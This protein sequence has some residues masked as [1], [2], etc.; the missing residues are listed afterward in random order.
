VLFCDALSKQH[1]QS[2]S[3]DES[4]GGSSTTRSAALP[5][6][7]GG[8]VG[9]VGL[10][11]LFAGGL[12]VMRTRRT[13]L[14]RIAPS[15][16]QPVDV[17]L[18]QQMQGSDSGDAAATGRGRGVANE[19]PATRAMP[20]IITSSEEKGLSCLQA[21]DEASTRS[22]QPLSAASTNGGAASSQG[23]A[24]QLAVKLHSTPSTLPTGQ[25]SPR[26]RSA[27]SKRAAASLPGVTV[28]TET[29]G[30]TPSEMDQRETS[31][32]SSTLSWSSTPTRK[33]QVAP[34]GAECYRDIK[35]QGPKASRILGPAASSVRSSSSLR[36]GSI[37]TGGLTCLGSGSSSRPLSPAST[38]AS[39]PIKAKGGT[40]NNGG[41]GAIFGLPSTAVHPVGIEHR[42]HSSSVASVAGMKASP[43]ADVK[44][45]VEAGAIDGPDVVQS[46]SDSPGPDTLRA[47]SAGAQTESSSVILPWRSPRKGDISAQRPPKQNLQNYSD[48]NGDAASGFALQTGDAV[49]QGH[50]FMA[51]TDTKAT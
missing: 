29:L 7:I 36:G 2:F 37:D 5:A 20:D 35:V 32:P 43:G 23:A 24:D 26:S 50:P 12:Y 46:L 15:S 8:V 39:S 33:N 19:A 48:E 17:S 4:A 28:D 38:A 3:G 6:I 49:T 16:P 42:Q 31:T 27:S 14:T 30:S 1:A 47:S 18:P 13:Q 22:T 51:P 41:F 40:P 45:D 25:G 44:P 11:A 10:L 34:L 21:G 9:G